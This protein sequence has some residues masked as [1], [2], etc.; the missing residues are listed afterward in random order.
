MPGLNLFSHP[1]AGQPFGTALEL[2]LGIVVL[3]WVVSLVTGDFC[4]W[5][6]RLWP[7]CPPVYCL[8]VAVE[9]DFDVARVNLMTA[10]VF[11]WSARLT[12]NFARK[13]GFRKGGTDYRWAIAQER[14]GPRWFQPANITFIVPGQLLLIWLFTS[15][16]HQAWAWRDQPLRWLDGLSLVLFLACFS[17]QVIADGQMWRF[18]QDKKRRMEAGEE[19]VQPFMVTGLFRYSRHPSY[20]CEIGMW[21]AF[22][23]F[24]VSASGQWVHWTGLG[25]VLLVVQFIF[26]I[27]MTERI[28]AG[29]YPAYPE[30]QARTPMLLPLPRFRS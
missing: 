30:Y 21:F 5:L 11:L 24:A 22:Y 4:V 25:L 18:Q 29:K 9:G 15:P 10:L 17:V 16:V 28:S 14:L 7:L 2:C 26:V 13:G 27:G 3:G 1:L 23:L 8:L 19:V 20:L 6:D 12:H